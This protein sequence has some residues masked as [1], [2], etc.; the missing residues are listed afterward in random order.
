MHTGSL[1]LST[2]LSTPKFDNPHSVVIISSKESSRI[3]L[4]NLGGEL[5]SVT[6]S[7]PVVL[8]MSE[9]AAI[10]LSN[11]ICVFL[12]ELESPFLTEM[13]SERLSQV[14]K[15]CQAK[16]LLWVV[17]GAY[18]QSENPNT[19]MVLGLARTI[20]SENASVKFATL[21]LDQRQRLSANDTTGVVIKVFTEIFQSGLVLR[22]NDLEYSERNGILYVPRLVKDSKLDGYIQ[23]QTQ[24]LVPERQ[25]YFQE[26]RSLTL[27]VGAPGSL[28]SFFF[29]D[30]RAVTTE[31]KEDEVLIEIKAMGLNFKDVLIALGQIEDHMGKECTGIITD[32][33]GKVTNL[34]KGD[35]VCALPRE[36]YSTYAR[37]DSSAVVKISDEMSFAIA[38]SIPVVYCTAYY[39]LIDLAHLQRGESVLV[40]AAAGGVGQAAIMLAQMIGAEVFA[41]VGSKQKKHFLMDTYGLAEDHIYSSRTSAFGKS[42]RGITKNRGVDVVLNSLSGEKLLT[43]WT[44]LAKFGRFIEIG[45]KDILA[46]TRL[47]MAQFSQ[48]VTFSSVDLVL[49][50]EERPQLIQRLLSDVFD[51]IRSGAVKPI[52]PITTYSIQDIEKGFRALQSGNTI[53]K[54][55][56]EPQMEDEVMVSYSDLAM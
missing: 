25:R 17:E 45:K 36:S 38:A 32:V 46:N 12:D 18:M 3:S 47:E 29:E 20:R 43:S 53:G 39:S 5:T 26:A 21:D 34:Q 55:V 35:R 31:L 28:D 48:S 8:S 16:G 11:R 51:L 27:R 56:F 23:R 6:G 49:V 7:S 52:S 15:L 14:Q 54:I 40:H 2:A 4:S 22:E 9:A 50:I 42:I 24:G 37:C 44:C 19:N 41:T 10:D 30:Q 1:M 13:E 33:G